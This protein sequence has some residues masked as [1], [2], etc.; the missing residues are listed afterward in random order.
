MFVDEFGLNLAMTRRY[1]RAPRG[2]RAIGTA[3]VAYGNNVTLVMGVRLSGPVAPMLV[4]GAM[5]R[6]VWDGYVDEFLAPC[7]RP[8]DIVV[9]DRLQAHLSMAAFTR[10]ETQGAQVDLLPP[11]SPDWS[12]AEPCGSKVKTMMRAAAAR[13]FEDLIEAAGHALRSV[14]PS[15]AL[16]WFFHCGYPVPFKVKPL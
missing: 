12:P 9:F 4:R 15:D 1:G 10:I 16:G 13:T 8:A 6:L 7:L 14:T 2:E 3:P 11:Y 5:N